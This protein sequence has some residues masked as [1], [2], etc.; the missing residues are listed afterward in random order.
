[1][2]MTEP[3]DVGSTID[4]TAI[5]VATKEE[6]SRGESFN[7]ALTRNPK[8]KGPR[9]AGLLNRGLNFDS[10][11]F[12][13]TLGATVDAA[14]A[15]PKIFKKYVSKLDE[16]YYCQICMCNESLEECGHTLDC[17]HTFCKSCISQYLTIKVTEAQVDSFVCPFVP[18]DFL[19][20]Q[21]EGWSCA[22][23]TFFNTG[24]PPAG[25]R[26]TCAVCATEQ[27]APPQGEA[28]CHS[29]I[30]TEMLEMIVDS[31]TMDKFK[32]FK[33]MKGGLRRSFF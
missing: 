19:Q 2:A 27:D 30:S 18:D 7:T 11:P 25:G 15:T 21:G 9:R 8:A 20:H 33:E 16:T 10:N 32:R 14:S 28:G 31:E 17:G 23:C 5:N 4:H 26:V 1:M 3:P 13:R 29:V 24:E 12:M 6:F 22:E